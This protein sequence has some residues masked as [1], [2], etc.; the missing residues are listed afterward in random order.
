MLLKQGYYTAPGASGA[1]VIITNFLP[2]EAFNF[3]EL[4]REY[5]ALT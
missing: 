3:D 2:N 5:F 4:L 1:Q